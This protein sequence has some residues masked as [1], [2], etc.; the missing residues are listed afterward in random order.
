V[1]QFA[2]VSSKRNS[3]TIDFNGTLVFGFKK[4]DSANLIMQCILSYK[5]QSV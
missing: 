3:T 1:I 5:K 4:K 2:N